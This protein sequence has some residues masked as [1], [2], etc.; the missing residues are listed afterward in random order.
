MPV[1]RT[2]CPPAFVIVMFLGVCLPAHGQE[3]LTLEDYLRRV[4]GANADIR[5]AD[6]A[7]Q[8]LGQK[9][10]ESD[11][12]YSPFLS[13]TYSYLDDKS[14]PGLTSSF[15]ANETIAHSW[16]VSASEKFGTGTTLSLGYT[17]SDTQLDLFLPQTFGPYS[18][19]DFSGYAIKPFVS[20]QQSLLRDFMAGLT[21]TGINK[22]KAAARAGQYQQLFRRQQVLFRARAAYWSLSLARDVTAFRRTSLDRTE[23]LLHWNEQRVK[24]DLAD[25]GDLL[26]A[27]A[28]FKLRQLNLQQALEDEVKAGRD[29]NELLGNTGGAFAPD[30]EKLSERI[31]TY[32]CVTCLAKT[33]ERPDVLASRASFAGSRWAKEETF[34]RSLPELSL[35][36]SYASNGSDFLSFLPGQDSPGEQVGKFAN[37]TLAASLSLIVPLDFPTLSKVRA[38]YEKDFQSSRAALAQAELSAG[39]DWQNLLKQWQD[40]KTRLA[41]AQEI[42]AIQEQR[43]ANEQRRFERGRSTTFLLLTAENDLDDAALNVYRLV[44][45][46]MLIAAQAELF[47]T[48][49]LNPEDQP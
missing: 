46:E 1:P 20:V 8:A 28:A 45:E 37:P 42:K 19:S 9:V 35:S 32:A 12:V 3:L 7:F 6:L 48:Q 18:F 43:V 10:L 41:L 29:A 39:K 31:A 40:V 47:N 38:G 30:L 23:K 4:E 26:Q 2:L 17:Y 49:P 22:A 33:G 25:A 15:L 24:M 11:M 13:A 27:Q 44:M 16:N 36:A 5:A 21:Q 34:Y 14:G